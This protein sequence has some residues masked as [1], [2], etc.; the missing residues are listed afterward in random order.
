MNSR[1]IFTRTRLPCRSRWQGSAVACFGSGGSAGFVYFLDPASR[2]NE[3][4]WVDND[5]VIKVP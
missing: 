5:Y 4:S 2:V 3:L 1:A